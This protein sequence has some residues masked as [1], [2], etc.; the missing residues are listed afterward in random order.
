MRLLSVSADA[1]T[2]KGR[3]YGYLT[4]ILYLA[5]ASESGVNVCASSTP[6]CRAGCL[7]TAGRGGVFP[8]VN[9][10]RLKRTRMLIA[11]RGAFLSQLAREIT[12]FVRKAGRLG[13]TPCVRV[14]GTS[15]LPWLALEMAA[16]FPMVQLYDYTKHARPWE[17][18]RHNYHLT[19]SHSESNA[20]EC[21]A[22]LEHGVN[23][24]VV[25]D[26]KRDQSLPISFYQTRNRVIDGDV[27]DL[28]FLDK[29]VS[30]RGVPQGRG[31][32]VGLRA[33]GRAR[34]DCSG[35]VVPVRL[36]QIQTG[37]AA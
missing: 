32:I 10:A 17:R 18:V 4:G 16:R 36:V 30:V 31:V 13:L 19:F 28:R 23:V 15:D 37:R 27:S 6:R 5:P 8:S 33:K 2:V 26:T 20:A 12:A 29:F 22:A 7:Y 21:E 1:K 3:K 25:F 11:N 9:R 24:A 34:K 14:N 35:F